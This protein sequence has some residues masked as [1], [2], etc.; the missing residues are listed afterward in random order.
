MRDDDIVDILQDLADRDGKVIEWHRQV[1]LH[2]V[3]NMVGAAGNV[4]EA[5]DM[6]GGASHGSMRNVLPAYTRRL[7]AL[8]ICVIFIECESSFSRRYYT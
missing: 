8:R 1:L 4:D 2:R 7:V 3:G 6:P 5:E